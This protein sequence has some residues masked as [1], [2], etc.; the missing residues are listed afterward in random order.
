MSHLGSDLAATGGCVYILDLPDRERTDIMCFSRV[1]RAEVRCVQLSESTPYMRAS[2]SQHDLYSIS[3]LHFGGTI[4]SHV[5]LDTAVAMVADLLDVVDVPVWW[6]RMPNG[7][8]ER[9]LEPRALVR[10]PGNTP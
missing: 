8:W 3:A 1:P 2:G 6:Q 7:T 10:P 5:P 9:S 4:A